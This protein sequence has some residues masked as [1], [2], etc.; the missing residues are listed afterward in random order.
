MVVKV[1]YESFIEDN[2][3]QDVIFLLGKKD[4]VYPYINKCKY[5]LL[6]TKQDLDKYLYPSIVLK[7]QVISL[8]RYSDDIINVGENYGFIVSDINKL[9]E[10][11]KK[12]LKIKTI[13]NKII[14]FEK[15]NDKKAKEL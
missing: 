12:I 11:L 7:T 9:K 13:K 2:Y 1:A 15:I 14:D 10:K 5:I 8:C 4:N 6:N 3:L